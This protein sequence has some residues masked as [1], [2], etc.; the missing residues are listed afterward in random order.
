MKPW[1]KYQED[2]RDLFIAL[3][4]G[5]ETDYSV[6]GV[7]TSH[8]IDVFV[9]TEFKGFRIK[10]LVECKLWKTPVTKLHVLALREIVTDVGAD[11]GII[12]SESGFQRGAQEAANLTNVHLASLASIG[13]SASQEFSLMA[14]HEL[15]DKAEENKIIYWDIPKLT[16]I[17]Y[18][19]RYDVGAFGYSGNV[20]SEFCLDVLSKA[21][22]NVYPFTITSNEGYQLFG[23]GMEFQNAKGVLS[24]VQPLVEE[25]AEKLEFCRTQESK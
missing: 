7:R 16:R 17:K 13:D 10:W 21:L 18:G 2:V 15:Y 1:R 19:L 9:S 3:G 11:R 20:V 6:E 22:R 5:A 23:K 4:L 12:L 25:L 14:I 8:D 24:I